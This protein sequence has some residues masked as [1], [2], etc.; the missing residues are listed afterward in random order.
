MVP[1]WYR[2]ENTGEVDVENMNAGNNASP[3]KMENS[4]RDRCNTIRTKGDHVLLLIISTM[5]TG[6]LNL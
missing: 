1:K 5:S 2:Q 3:G 4:K 6:S